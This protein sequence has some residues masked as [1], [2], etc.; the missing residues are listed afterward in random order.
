MTLFSHK[1]WLVNAKRWEGPSAPQATPTTVCTGLSVRVTSKI[2][3]G[4]AFEL[5][6]PPTERWLPLDSHPG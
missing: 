6:S 1:P 2:E 5:T 4:L 3:S